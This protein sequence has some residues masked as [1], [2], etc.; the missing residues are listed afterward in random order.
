MVEIGYKIRK[1]R[2]ALKLKNSELADGIGHHRSSFCRYELGKTAIRI[3]TL[4]KLGAKYNV[5]LDWLIRDK[6]EMFYTEKAVS[7]PEKEKIET[8][9]PPPQPAVDP[10][11]PDIRELADHME[12]IPLLRYEI[13]TYF[14]KFKD[15]NKEMVAN[16]FINHTK[17]EKG[18]D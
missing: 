13:L 2:E 1:V 17:E 3:M 10:I 16:A 9:A 18:I 5:S 14:H 4:Y 6:G 15:K 8:P 12:R 7:E 11:P